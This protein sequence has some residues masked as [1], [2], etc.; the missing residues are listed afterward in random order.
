MIGAI[1]LSSSS[2]PLHMFL[3]VINVI[4]CLAFI[5]FAYLNLN[6]VDPWLWVPIYLCAA[7]CCGL[8]VFGFYYPWIYLGLMA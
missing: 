7:A 4:F 3:V 8:V 2:Y 1:S 6:D 5:Y